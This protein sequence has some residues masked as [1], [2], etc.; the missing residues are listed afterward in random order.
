MQ[1]EKQTNTAEY[2]DNDSSLFDYI[3]DKLMLMED[4]HPIPNI[5]Q[6]K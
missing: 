1:A 5:E 6:M 2:H 4:F 3:E